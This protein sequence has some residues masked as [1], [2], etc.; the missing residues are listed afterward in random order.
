MF[1]YPPPLFFAVL[2]KNITQNSEK[3]G[4]VGNKKGLKT[5]RL[6]QNSA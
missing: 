4:G 2:C 3:E 5:R 1:Y 6:S